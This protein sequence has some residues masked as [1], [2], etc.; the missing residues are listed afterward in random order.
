M[1]TTGANSANAGIPAQRSRSR[2][3]SPGPHLPADHQTGQRQFQT[4]RELIQG[5][6]GLAAAPAQL[7]VPAPA[8]SQQLLAQ[9]LQAQ[10]LQNQMLAEQLK[11]MQQCRANSSK[12]Y[13]Q[14]HEVLEAIDP[15]LAT[16]PAQWAK[17][18]RS[19]LNHAVTQQGLQHKYQDLEATG[20]T[21]KQFQMEALKKWQ[22]PDPFKAKARKMTTTRPVLNEGEQDEYELPA[23]N[24]PPFNVEEA[25]AAMRKRHAKECHDFVLA[26]Q[27]QCA[28]S[29]RGSPNSPDDQSGRRPLFL[30]AQKP[31]SAEPHSPS[32]PPAASQTLR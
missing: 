15:S 32:Q 21:H 2:A 5:P 18:Y 22:W 19:S 13:T 30:D 27:R 8:A 25:F 6:P 14:P 31:G 17:E 20:E 10:Q 3:L 4:A 28:L 16:E 7:Q 1:Q 9:L 24:A 23:E 26:Y 12:T 29:G 11:L